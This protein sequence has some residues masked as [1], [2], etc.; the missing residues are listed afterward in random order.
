MSLRAEASSASEIT[1]FSRRRRSD[2]HSGPGGPAGGGA[3]GT[4][5]VGGCA[6]GSGRSVDG[7][8]PVGSGGGVGGAGCARAPRRAPATASTAAADRAR[9]FMG[10]SFSRKDGDE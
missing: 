2:V 7:G 10:T 9:D 4:D 3:D 1:P 8:C 6:V 5:A